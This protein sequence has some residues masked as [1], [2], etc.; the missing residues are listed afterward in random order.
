MKPRP[1]FMVV[2]DE[3]IN[4]IIAELLINRVTG[5]KNVILFSEPEIALMAING[6]LN[7]P[8]EV[9]TILLLDLNMSTMTGW[10]FLDVYNAF[11]PS[12]HEHYQIYILTSSIDERDELKSLSY[13]LVRGIFSKPL[14]AT[15]IHKMLSAA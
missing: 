14:T 4:T 3:K 7:K 8:G 5:E 10:E 11:D 15:T 6:V 13:P 12:V 9:N 2:D 1:R